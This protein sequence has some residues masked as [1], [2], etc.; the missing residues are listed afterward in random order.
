[1]RSI[2]VASFA[3]LGCSTSTSGA[4]SGSSDADAFVGT[5]A[6]SGMTTLTCPPEGTPA[7]TAVTGNLVITLGSASGT[8]VSTSPEG[9]MGFFTISGNLATAMTFVPCT[10]AGDATFDG[11]LTGTS[12]TLTLSSSGE[13]LA[14]AFTGTLVKGSGGTMETCSETATGTFTKS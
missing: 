5:W 11:V 8:I 12:H 3:L 1:M 4:P 9:C 6:R 13:S 10:I 2:L 7:V 14:E